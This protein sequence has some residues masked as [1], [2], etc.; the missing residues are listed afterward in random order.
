MVAPAVVSLMVTVCAA[1]Y[2][3]AA[4][5]KAGV[6]AVGSAAAFPVREKVAELVTPLVVAVAVK[7]PVVVGVAVTEASPFDPV[8]AAELEK[9]NP[10]PEK[11]TITPG[12]GFPFA[13]FT[14]ATSGLAKAEPEVALCPDPETA[15]ILAAAPTIVS[16][17]VPLLAE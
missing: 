5:E 7:L 12:I 14:M 16:V 9:L 8:V 15:L 11:L 2:V 6:A 1:V 3:P 10:V 17:S 4:G 13:S